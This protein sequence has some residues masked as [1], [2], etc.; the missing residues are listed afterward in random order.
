VIIEME[1]AELEQ[2]QKLLAQHRRN[3]N[4]LEHQAAQHGLY[5]PL[6]IH[7]AMA[8][9]HEAIVNL[10]RELAAAGISPQPQPSWQALLIDGDHHWREI[11]NNHIRQLGGTVIECQT[12]PTQEIV[13]ACGVAI[14]S[15]SAYAQTDLTA[16]EWVKSVVNLGQSLPI[17]LLASW[18]DRETSIRLR[19][20]LRGNNQTI[21][22]T[23]IFKETFDFH[24]FSQIIHQVLTH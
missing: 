6:A 19:Q 22:S 24:W 17:I 2:K 12:I 5:V 3:L 1:Q 18:E 13:D 11:I 8:V 4:Y 23:T 9:E 10:E 7:N 15:A 21:S 14:V 20:A 16:S